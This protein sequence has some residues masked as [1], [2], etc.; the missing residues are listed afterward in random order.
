MAIDT[1]KYRN[2]V[3]LLAGE[4]KI[5]IVTPVYKNDPSPLLNAIANELRNADYKNKIEL[6]LVDDGSKMPELSELIKTRLLSMPV[7]ALSLEFTQNQGRSSARNA[8][9]E[10]S[11]A[12]YL[13]FLDSDMLPDCPNFIFKWLEFIE[14]TKPTIAYG[15]FS[16][17][18]AS[19]EPKFA[20]ARELASRI[21][22]LNALE[23]NE[24][25]SVAVATSNLLVRRDIMEEVPFDN[26]F[27]GW[28]WEDVD[29]A[30]RANAAKYAVVH[31]ENAATHLGIDEAELILHKFKHA[32]PNFCHITT[33]HPQMLHLGSTKLAIYLSKIPFLTM[34]APIA[35]WFA[36]NEIVPIKLRARAA[37]FWRVIWAANSLVEAK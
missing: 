29:W 16:M 24:R 15:G 23:R 10:N 7:S 8:L 13:L 22:C 12:P 25:G 4:L 34:L 31:Y 17:L 18:Q 32:G 36:I 1:I 6:V 27:V 30:L 11:I 26:G 3:P 2:D 9:I 5:A 21:D 33:R 28:G 20:L 14:R 35:K 19:K 37:R